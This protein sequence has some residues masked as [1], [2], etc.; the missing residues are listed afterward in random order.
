VAQAADKKGVSPAY[1]GVTVG[2][3]EQVAETAVTCPSSS[4]SL[5]STPEVILNT[6]QN[7]RSD[8]SIVFS[9]TNSSANYDGQ[10]AITDLND[11]YEGNSINPIHTL[12]PNDNSTLSSDLQISRKG[13]ISPVRSHTFI[14]PPVFEQSDFLG[15]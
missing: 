6:D 2:S 13:D 12:T 3:K 15:T 11:G 5:A 8:T 14:Q 10:L 7:D 4:F 1:P 9:V